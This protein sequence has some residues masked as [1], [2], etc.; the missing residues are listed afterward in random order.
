[1]GF[2]NIDV[3]VPTE[4]GILVTEYAN[5]NT[6]D[7]T[8]VLLLAAARRIVEKYQFLHAAVGK[9]GDRS[10]G[11]PRRSSPDARTLGLGRIGQAVARREELSMRIL[12]ND[13]ACAPSMSR[14]RSGAEYVPFEHMLRESDFI[15]IH[16]PLSAA[17][18]KLIGAPS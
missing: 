5:H 18:R 4:A 17:T 1:M 7:L 6:A 3:P 13:A 12:Y 15:S 9:M 10:A 8:F 2:D 11:R 14:S 16:V